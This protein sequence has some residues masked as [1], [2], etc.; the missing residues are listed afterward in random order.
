MDE[1][2]ANT[3]NRPTLKDIAHTAG[4]S[5]STVSIVLTGKAAERRISAQVVQRVQSVAAQK[6][7]A[8]NLL[9]H[10]LRQGRTQILSFYN[11]YG[12][13][14]RGDLYMDRLTTALEQAAGGRHY[15]IL[16]HCDFARP[17]DEIYRLLNGG[18]ADGLI[19]FGP[20][21]DDPLLS[22]FK[23]S[24]LPTVIL[25]HSDE[26][27]ILSAVSEDM[28]SGMRMIATELVA[29][30]HRR[31]AALTGPWADA[32]ARI[33]SLRAHLAEWDILLPEHRVV[34]VSEDDVGL[35]AVLHDLMASPNPPTALFCWHDRVGYHMLEA[36]ERAGIAVPEQLSL[37]G[38]DGLHWPSRSP[39]LLASVV[40][41]LT[42][43]AESA[44]GLLDDLITGKVRPPQNIV[45]P[46]E[47]QRGTTLAASPP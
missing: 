35:D 30:G 22:L 43:L 1:I 46:V 25:T 15:D 5:I 44:V 20:Q 3:N 21:Q 13:R 32:G 16:T 36:C 40:I 37:V 2:T 42:A 31:I 27:G 34:P 33:E 4:V 18:R 6:D 29:L 47:L 19:F 14:N 8:P 28:P 9:M 41:D 39:H 24:R 11:G 26:T 45:H 12:R 17:V 7:Y 10:S 38:Y 23:A